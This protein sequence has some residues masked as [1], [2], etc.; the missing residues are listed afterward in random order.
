MPS[1]T[2]QAVDDQGRFQ[3]GKIDSESVAAANEKLFQNGLQPI[4]VK[5]TNVTSASTDAPPTKRLRKVK[6]EDLI[7]YTKQMITMI[8]VGIPIAQCLEILETQSESPTLARL[9]RKIRI[10]IED[11]SSL[12][13]ALSKHP[14][15]FSSL[16]CTIVSAGE[17]SGTLPNSM[18]RLLYLVEHEEEVK[19]EV[20]SALRYPTF[21]II[22]LAIAFV[23]ML[24]WVVP[25]FAGFFERADLEL[26]L[27]TQICMA[28]SA[29]LLDWGP[30]L[31][32]VLVLGFLWFR[33]ALKKEA[34]RLRWDR[35]LLNTPLIGPVLVKAAMTRFTSIFAILQRSGY[36]ILE[37]IEILARTMDN[38][39]LAHEFLKLRQSLQEGKGISQPLRDARFFP[40]LV[41]SMIAIG[42]E[43]GKLDDMLQK[44]SEHYD[45]ELRYTMKKMT[46]AI[47]PLLIVLL[48]FAVGFFALAIYLPM[49]D[50]TQM[51]IE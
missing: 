40:P 41:V 11:G 3:R 33:F 1:F 23:V 43:T 46:S 29:L 26:P 50:L 8:R 16:Y 27:P 32:F 31:A 20:R 25:T 37:S 2:F 14:K 28:L 34:V 5:E 49:W 38:T 19:Q 36:L 35:L 47:G 13:E 22:A 17:K 15:V 48:T 9:S 6:A 4:S 44:I 21:V 24:G 18:E 39:A 51:A 45:V 10:D 42:E 30:A 7:L 12:S